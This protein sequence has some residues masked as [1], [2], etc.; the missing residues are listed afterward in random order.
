MK[1]KIYMF[2]GRVITEVISIEPMTGLNNAFKIEIPSKGFGP[3]TKTTSTIGDYIYKNTDELLDAI[4][5][6]I[7]YL[8][9]QIMKI[10]RGELDEK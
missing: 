7:Y 4:Q 1:N 9:D 10:E 3:K 8:E 2:D 5:E 6:H